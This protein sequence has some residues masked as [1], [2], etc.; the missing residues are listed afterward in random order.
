MLSANNLEVTVNNGYEFIVGE[1]LRKLPAETQKHLLEYSNYTSSWTYTDPQG[2]QVVVRY[3]SVAYQGRTIIGTY[4]AKRAG[5]DAHDRDARLQTA[6]KLMANPSL[7]T[8]KAGRFFLKKEGKTTYELD[9]DR[10]RSDKKFDG[11]LAIATNNK[12]L[13][14]HTIL[15][16]YNSLYKIEASF[17]SFKSHLETRSMFHWTDKRIE[18]H[19]CLCYISFTLLNYTLLKLEKAG[20]KKLPRA[21]YETSWIR[22]R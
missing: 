20:Y 5:K 9:Q 4:S 3:C 15:E 18:G 19:L 22:S 2:E 1:L 10:I 11:F 13:P 6:Q 7:I 8:K 12:T 17:R 21:S 14:V 16:N